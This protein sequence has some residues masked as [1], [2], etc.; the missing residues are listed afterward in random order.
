M[1]KR[2]KIAVIPG[3]G[4]GPEVMNTLLEILQV[5]NLPLDF[6][7]FVIGE[8]QYLKSGTSLRDED[9]EELKKC[10]A[11]LFGALSTPSKD[12]PNYKSAILG[13]RKGLDLHAN[14]RPI[15]NKKKNIDIYVFRENTEDLYS[16]KEFFRKPGEEAVAEKIITKQATE[17]IVDS[18]IDFFRKNKRKKMTIVHK[19]NVLRTSDGFFRDIC[20]EHLDKENI[21]YNEEYVDACAYKLIKFPENFDVIVTSNMYGDILS[22]LGGALVDNLGMLPSINKGEEHSLYEPVHGSAPDIAD[23]D[24]VNPYAMILCGAYMLSDLGF[25]KESERIFKLIDDF[26][27]KDITAISVGGKYKNSEI[28]DKFKEALKNK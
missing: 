18:A 17:K 27:E 11:I 13:L 24:I 26:V 14:I 12:Y 4:V 5:L 19:A 20:R 22:D 28:G 8:K 1:P 10:D 21:P 6:E 2:Y 7:E 9:F 16:Q 15:I 3:D 23:K 25:E